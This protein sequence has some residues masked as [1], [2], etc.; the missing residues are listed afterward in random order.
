MSLEDT[1]FIFRR[2]SE[3]TNQRIERDRRTLKPWTTRFYPNHLDLGGDPEDGD[4]VIYGPK[5]SGAG[6]G[7]PSF[8]IWMIP[9]S[10]YEPDPA[11]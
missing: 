6:C 11:A 4:I 7:Q 2:H 1:D 9:G 8:S 3:I 10:G 5:D